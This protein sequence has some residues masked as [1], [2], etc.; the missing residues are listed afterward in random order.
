[1]TLE[2]IGYINAKQAQ[3]TPPT[4]AGSPALCRQTATY[5][6][7]THAGDRADDRA[8]ISPTASSNDVNPG[9]VARPA[10]RRQVQ[11]HIYYQI[12]LGSLPFTR[13]IT[14]RAIILP[15]HRTAL[16]QTRERGQAPGL[17]RPA[18]PARSSH[19]PPS[20]RLRRSIGP[21]GRR[22]KRPAPRSLPAPASWSQV[23]SA[24]Q[25]PAQSTGVPSG[26]SSHTLRSGIC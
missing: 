9:R 24:E 8:S 4:Q 6:Q 3:P 7:A 22:N 20:P 16:H 5:L 18:Y 12:E 14:R 26:I 19:F 1:M 13:L 17:T 23:T 15:S 10:Y 21:E 25:T 2:G 11:K